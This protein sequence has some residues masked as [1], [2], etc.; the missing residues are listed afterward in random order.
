VVPQNLLD[1]SR[2][3]GRGRRQCRQRHHGHQRGQV[4][5][6]LRGYPVELV[7][8]SAAA[9]PLVQVLAGGQAPQPRVGP[10]RVRVAA[11]RQAVHLDEQC[12]SA[13]H[14]LVEPHVPFAD[15]GT[16]GL[17]APSAHATEAD[18]VSAG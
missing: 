15:G 5:G 12:R 4:A 17:H 16:G 10:C 1:D 13:P 18:R 6:A 2:K 9:H 14:A 11:V 7:L 8:D 3:L